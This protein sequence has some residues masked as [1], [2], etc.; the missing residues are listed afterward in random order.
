[1]STSNPLGGNSSHGTAPD[2]SS[3]DTSANAAS[4]DCSSES[5]VLEARNDA[6]RHDAVSPRQVAPLP[7]VEI[8][9][10]HLDMSELVSEAIADHPD[11]SADDIVRLLAKKQ[12]HVPATLVLQL[13]SRPGAQRNAAGD[14]AASTAPSQTSPKQR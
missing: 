9:Q 7:H 11:A 14:D 10:E 12:I 1:M 6:T 13:L 3:S 8:Q 2:V 5:R 4:G